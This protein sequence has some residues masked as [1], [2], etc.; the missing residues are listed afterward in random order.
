MCGVAVLAGGSPAS[1]S[2]VWA[3]L[4]SIRHRGPDGAGV[5]AFGPDG[6]T[7]QRTPDE[8]PTRGGVV[9]G[10]ARLAIIDLSD[11][12]F[13]PMTS[14][15]SSVWV[16]CNGELYNHHEL[17]RELEARG[18]RFRSRSD[19]EVL[20]H[21]Y[22]EWG[23]HVLERVEGMFAFALH[24]R[25]RHVTLLA[26][27]RLGVK[28][29]YH[30][31][32]PDGALVAASEI[33]ALL[34]A[35][36]EARLD[37]AGLDAFLTWL[38]VP[39]PD[40]AFEGVKKLEP[41]TLMRIDADGRTST[42]RYWDFGWTHEAGPRAE[43]GELRAA[44]AA[45]VERQLQSDVPL[46]AFFSGGLDSTAIVE[47]MRR[48]IAP[49]LPTC[50]T[51]GF[52]ERDLRCEAVVD[53]LVYARR[54]AERT[55]VDYREMVL[56]PGLAHALPEVVWHL[57][58]P[59][60]D[61]AALSSY[62]IC[63]AARGDL[64]VL[65]S[66]MGGDELFGGYP[67]YVATVL[68]GAARA[69][70][71][72]IRRALQAATDLMPV[73]GPGAV[74]KFRS[75]AG[76]LLASAD[77]RFPDDY[78]GFLTSLDLEARRALYSDDLAAATAGM[79]ADRVHRLHLA[80]AGSPHWLDQAMHLDLKTFLASH[81]LVYVDKTS[82]AHSIEVRVPLLD[83]LV[84]DVV[85]RM[86]PQDRVSGRRTK[87]LFKEA[88]RGIVPDEI[89]DRRKAGFGAPLRGW[90]ANELRPLVDDLLSPAA[91][92]RRGLFR[93]EAVGQ[94]VADFRS[95]RRD[96]A[97]QLWQLLTLELWHGAFLDSGSRARP[98]ALAAAR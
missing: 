49:E 76:K 24:D 64:T 4:A 22:E 66:G 79:S 75:R 61:P 72:P 94:L 54:Y 47:L 83:E 70:P 11:A 39:D 62:R 52:S 67:R 5:V 69:V 85:R 33:K 71:R 13:Q 73:S 43:P 41:G 77:A 60:A 20:V 98:A 30:A 68:A 84:L 3:M 87:I 9:L 96:T 37:P 80:G 15:D 63:E 90:L 51:V 29:L 32:R 10:H 95:G 88:M 86:A 42:S 46:G 35:G 26:R 65:L 45:A 89:V 21:G 17:R 23:E 8:P 16:I 56:D 1:T 53:D 97:Y 14:E 36:V 81:N 34:A 25:D 38:W 50:L 18:H 44:V 92:R 40:T 6:A 78:L 58:E 93:P 48:S 27:D 82:M 2:D 12:G 7:V 91:V 59:I 74:A 19:T 57:D 55:R 31:R 28:P